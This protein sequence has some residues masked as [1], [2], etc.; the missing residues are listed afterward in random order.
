[1]SCDGLQRNCR[2]RD[3]NPLCNLEKKLQ[4]LKIESVNPV[5]HSINRRAQNTED[6]RLRCIELVEDAPIGQLQGGW[7]LESLESGYLREL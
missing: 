4:P 6:G 7:K 3:C 5:M 1:M 2:S